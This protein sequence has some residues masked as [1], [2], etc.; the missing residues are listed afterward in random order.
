MTRTNRL[1][2]KYVKLEID[3]DNPPSDLYERGSRRCLKC[4]MRW[5]AYSIFLPT[6]CCN[7]NAELIQDPPDVTWAKA[8]QMLHQMRFERYYEKWNDNVTDEVILF[9][10]SIEIPLFDFDEEQLREGLEEIDRIVGEQRVNDEST[11]V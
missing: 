8:V 11:E 7:Q 1:F 5:P 6:P 4:S 9:D 2:P 10:D 3:P